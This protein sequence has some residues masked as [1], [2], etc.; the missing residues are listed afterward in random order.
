[1][2][3]RLVSGAVVVAA[4]VDVVVVSE[5][6][7]LAVVSSEE[8]PHAPINRAIEDPEGPQLIP[9]HFPAL[10]IGFVWQDR[11]FA[12]G[13]TTRDTARTEPYRAAKTSAG[14]AAMPV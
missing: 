6:V 1:M 5:V 4:V 14:V 9:I 8:P 11:M 7:S 13:G 3:A 2:I 10:H 12:D